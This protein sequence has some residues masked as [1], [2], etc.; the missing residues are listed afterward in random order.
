MEPDATDN[1]SRTYLYA[2]A[3]ACY[4]GN[5]IINI[6]FHFTVLAKSL[7]LDATLVMCFVDSSPPCLILS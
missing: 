4:I 5:T 1:V 7:E 6:S 2:Y 3:I